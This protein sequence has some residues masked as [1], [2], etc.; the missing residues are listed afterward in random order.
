M[1][2]KGQLKPRYKLKLNSVP[3]IEEL[4][5]E[6]YSEVD[7]NMVDIQ[8]QMN[9]LA[10]SVQL[11]DESIDAKTKYAKAMNDFIANKDKALGRKMEIAKLMT[12][13]HKHNG[14]V[15]AAVASNEDNFDLNALKS[16][17]MSEDGEEV[18]EYRE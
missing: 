3:K 9:R 10:N 18:I 13:I 1:A 17:L 2:T 5:Q 7:K 12:E 8:E 15:E 16:A 6:M 14:N 4:L 11:N